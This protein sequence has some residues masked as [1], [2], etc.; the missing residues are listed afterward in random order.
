MNFLRRISKADNYDIQTRTL[1]KYLL[2]IGCL[3]HRFLQYPPSHVAAAAMY[4]ARAVL[5][6]GAW[7]A[8]LAHYAGYTEQDI[9]PVFKLM[10]DYLHG[11]VVHDAFFRKYAS[12]KF[13][14]GKTIH[15]SSISSII[16]NN[17]RSFHHPSPM[18]K[19][20]CPQVP[21]HRRL[22]Y[23]ERQDSSLIILM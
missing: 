3:D 21:R 23:L 7:D 18:G 19:E 17:T 1:G 2:E 12:K 6:R 20:E 15:P 14:K 11:P 8:T 4:L 5:E 13:L 9:Q 10:V 16:A 22:R